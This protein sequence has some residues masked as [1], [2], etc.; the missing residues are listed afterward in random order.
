M[1]AKHVMM[2]AAVLLL[3]GAS[4]LRAQAPAPTPAQTFTTTCVACHGPVGTP[5]ADMVRM[6]GA[7][8]NFA[9]MRAPADSVWIRSITSGKG[10]MP[11]YG[12]RLNPAQ[13]RAM[14]TYIKPLKH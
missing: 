10:G 11:A 7:M 3:A 1:N 8:P 12:N 2:A 13:V 14:V 6:M 5:S 9:T 4:T